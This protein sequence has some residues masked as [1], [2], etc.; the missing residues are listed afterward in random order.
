VRF[1]QYRKPKLSKIESSEE[2]DAEE[3]IANKSVE[4]E[5]ERK[6]IALQ[7]TGDILC[8]VLASK[9]YSEIRYDKEYG[10]GTQ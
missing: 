2:K 6:C 4:Q 3:Q 10:A 1:R 5:G 7:K 9:P 8:I